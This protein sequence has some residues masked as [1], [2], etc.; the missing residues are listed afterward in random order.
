MTAATDPLCGLVAEALDVRAESV[1]DESSSDTIANWD[2]SAGMSLV[3]LIEETYGVT[4]EAG[5][6]ARLTS[7]GAIRQLLRQKGAHV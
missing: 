1:T 4:F 3:V 2:S 5:E 6:L 7:V